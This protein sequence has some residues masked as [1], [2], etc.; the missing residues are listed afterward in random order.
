[1]RILLAIDGSAYS[2]L[3]TQ[4]IASRPWPP[5]SELKIITAVET[6]VMIGMEPWAA[7][8]AYFDQLEK[9]LRENA[10]A[11][12]DKAVSRL[13][14]VDDKMLKISSEIIPGPPRQVILDEAE[15]WGAE[16]IVMGSRGLGTWNRLLLGSVS[17]AVIHHAHCSVEIVR[18][19]EKK[20]PA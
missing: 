19:R 20:G 17:S 16:L 5:Y 14:T 9:S 3:A 4:E 10:S 8:P 11:V 7:S 1:M 13:S 18:R 6:P 12:L 15:K 2:D